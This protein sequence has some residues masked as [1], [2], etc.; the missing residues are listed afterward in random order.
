MGHGQLRIY[1]RARG[2][3]GYIQY[4]YSGGRIMKRTWKMGQD[5]RKRHA[6]TRYKTK[7]FFGRLFIVV[8]VSNRRESPRRART[9]PV[10]VCVCVNIWEGEGREPA[11]IHEC[12]R[13]SPPCD[14]C[15]RRTVMKRTTCTGEG[16][17]RGIC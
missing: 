5:E 4:Y 14:H 7:T 6:Y 15:G 3:V 9:S 1:R 11:R 10:R 2:G 12:A 13:A 8:V 16:R 17:R